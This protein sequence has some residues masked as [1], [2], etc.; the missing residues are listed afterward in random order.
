MRNL[1]LPS[2]RARTSCSVL[3]LATVF[4]VG[5]T[6][7]SAQSFLGGGT[8]ATNGGGVA[9]ITTPTAT[10][11]TITV[12]PG[13]SV[14]DWI[15]TDNAIGG[16]NIAFQLSGTTATFTGASNFAV[17]NRINQADMNRAISLHKM[18]PMVDKVFPFE[19]AKQALQLMESGGHF[20]KIVIKF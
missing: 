7:A 14:I 3:A 2:R 10:T 15:P 17:L 5:P 6:P 9:L 8:F 1:A 19:E 18:K 12:N 16:G 13:Q 4:V 11:T 20:G